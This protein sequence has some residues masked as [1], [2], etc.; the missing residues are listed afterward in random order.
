MHRLF[1]E[2]I[3]LFFKVVVADE[4]YWREND[5]KFRAVAQHASYDQF[6]QIVKASHLKPLGAQDVGT[7]YIISAVLSLPFRAVLLANIYMITIV[8]MMCPP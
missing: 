1:E 2:V 6:E 7:R 3:D 4:R 8:T 5:A